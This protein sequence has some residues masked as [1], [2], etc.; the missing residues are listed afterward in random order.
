ML[1]VEEIKK[2]ML[3]RFQQAFYTAS[4][5][6]TQS[7]FP[8]P[9]STGDAIAATK[10]YTFMELVSEPLA[11]I[12]A[13]MI[14]S[15]IRNITLKGTIVTVGDAASQTAYIKPSPNPSLNGNS[16]NTLGI[17]EV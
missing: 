7:T 6:S 4:E 8:Q 14:D 12:I 17:C 10:A 3:G 15:A 9:S 11:D 1:S 5:V 13:Y 16:P 2:Q